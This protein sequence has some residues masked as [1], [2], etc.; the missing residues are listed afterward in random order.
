MDPVGGRRRRE[1]ESLG[2]E[3]MGSEDGW[4]WRMDIWDKDKPDGCKGLRRAENGHGLGLEMRT[5][6]W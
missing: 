5:A 3:I 4:I 6:S 1:L 2:E